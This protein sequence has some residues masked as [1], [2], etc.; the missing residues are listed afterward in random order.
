[1]LKR[2]VY[3]SVLKWVDFKNLVQMKRDTVPIPSDNVDE[4]DAVV[5]ALE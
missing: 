1:M 4:C 2:F 5:S 3:E